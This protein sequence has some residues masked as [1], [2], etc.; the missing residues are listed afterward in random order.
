MRNGSQGIDEVAD[1]APREPL[2]EDRAKSLVS[3]VLSSVCRK[4]S[5]SCYGSMAC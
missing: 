2:R 3:E 4:F 5:L 1:T